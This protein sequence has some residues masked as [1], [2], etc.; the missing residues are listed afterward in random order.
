MV[1]ILI[2]VIRAYKILISPILPQACRFYPSCSTYSVEAL[3]KYGL[4][5]GGYLS[6]RR[7]LK[8]HPWHPG[9]IDP[10]P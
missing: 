6:V 2:L 5:K 9:G 10:V 7:I 4:L 8:C 3:K 1:H